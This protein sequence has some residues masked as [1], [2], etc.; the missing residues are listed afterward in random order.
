MGDNVVE[1]ETGEGKQEVIN[2]V[3]RT[4]LEEAVFDLAE[5][6]IVN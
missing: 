5:S 6:D 2:L 1:F 4:L 3:V